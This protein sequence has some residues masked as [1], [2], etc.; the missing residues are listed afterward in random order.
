MGFQQTVVI[1][2]QDL[3]EHCPHEIFRARVLTPRGHAR[4]DALLDPF[5]GLACP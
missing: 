5:R 1:N 4:T 2:G 3:H